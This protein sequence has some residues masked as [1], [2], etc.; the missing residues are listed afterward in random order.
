MKRDEIVEKH[1]SYATIRIHRTMGGRPRLFGSPITDHRH[2]IR[3]SIAAA[4]RVHSLGYDRYHSSC[5][6]PIMQVEM[7]A[8]Q[9][10][11]L[12]TTVNSDETPCTL[13]IREGVRVEDPPDDVKVEADLVREKFGADVKA[14][15]AGLQPTVAAVEAI[16]AK[17]SLTNADRA[18]A[19][20][21]LHQFVRLIGD[22]APFM[23]SQFEEATQRITT[24]AKIEVD[25]FMTSVIVAA[26]IKAINEQG[27]DAVPGDTRPALPAPKEGT[28]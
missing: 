23:L 20:A 26:G 3:I 25:A 9:F 12:I 21:A 2:T 22:M 4:E 17:K 13:R 28:P 6:R 11:E 14:A 15:L 7:S 19:Q 5:N 1:P 16:L 27:L 10:A 8:A 24:T 18:A